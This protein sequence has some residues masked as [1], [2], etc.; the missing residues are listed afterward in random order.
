MNQVDAGCQGC[1]RPL[2]WSAVTEMLCR[3]C[4]KDRGRRGALRESG[5]PL[6]SEGDSVCFAMLGQELYGRIIRVAGASIA[7]EVPRKNRLP[8][9]WFVHPSLLRRNCVALEP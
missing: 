1:G 7:V 9:T 5:L 2:R 4:I 6:L 3:N 8:V